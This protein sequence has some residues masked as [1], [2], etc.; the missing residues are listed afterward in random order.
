MIEEENLALE[1]PAPINEIVDPVLLISEP[2]E[3][4]TPKGTKVEV[5]SVIFNCCVN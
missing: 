3:E 2:M 5:D 4:N 1:L